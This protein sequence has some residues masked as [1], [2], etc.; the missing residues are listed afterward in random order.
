[1]FLLEKQ[2]GFI[3]EK[4]LE[5]ER[6]IRFEMRTFTEWAFQ[7]NKQDKTVYTVGHWGN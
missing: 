2:F 6:K 4:A 5:L 3:E 7:Q 1:M